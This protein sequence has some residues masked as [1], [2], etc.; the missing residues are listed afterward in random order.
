MQLQIS[1][2]FAIILTFIYSCAVTAIE[3]DTSLSDVF[4]PSVGEAAGPNPGNTFTRMF[5]GIPPFAEQTVAVREASRSMGEK[6]GVLDAA[7]DLSDPI[8][9][10]TEPATFSPNNPDNPNMTAG[11]TFVGQFIDH[12]LTLDL[13]SSLSKNANPR[14]TNNFRTAAFDL[15]SVYGGGPNASPELY[16]RSSDDIKFRISEIPG[17]ESVSRHGAV[18]MGLPRG[19]DNVAIIGDGRNDENIIIAGLH[20]AMLGFHN[21]VVDRLRADPVHARDTPEQ[22]FEEAQ[23]LVKWHYQ[24]IIVNEFLP[25]TIGQSRVNALLKKGSRFYKP[26]RRGPSRR[27]GK[28]RRNPKIPVEF[29][30]AAYRFGHSQVRPSYRVNFGADENLGGEPFCFR[31]RR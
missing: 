16:D 26:G 28:G 22:I 2:V 23:R 4:S 12:D 24:W 17:S 11:V 1:Q 7:D 21:A 6:G 10:I 25:L 3:K 31:L 19:T 15:D 30:A 20:V 5:P 29:V 9:S 14:R 18:R 8:R 27:P 13:R